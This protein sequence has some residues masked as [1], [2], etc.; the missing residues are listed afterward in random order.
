M[1]MLGLQPAQYATMRGT[2]TACYRHC[3]TRVFCSTYVGCTCKHIACTL[4]K[5]NPVVLSQKRPKAALLHS[6]QTSCKE[7]QPDQHTQ[8][9]HNLHT[10]AG[11]LQRATGSEMNRV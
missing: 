2:Q 9:Q 4:A 7:R 8:Q 3:V 6:F 10:T 11:K 5:T 1:P